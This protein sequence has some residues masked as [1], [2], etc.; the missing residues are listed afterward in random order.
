[1]KFDITKMQKRGASGVDK[2]MTF[3][4]TGLIIVLLAVNLAPEMF[5]GVAGLENESG[6]PG[7]VPTVLYVI[8][9]AGIVFLIWKAFNGK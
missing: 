4:I 2:N 8:V 5:S 6:V 1:V 3:L 7:W 9:G